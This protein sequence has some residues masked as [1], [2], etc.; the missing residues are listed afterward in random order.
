VEIDPR[1]WVEAGGGGG[2]RGSNRDA[3]RKGW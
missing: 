2:G 1:R 3:G